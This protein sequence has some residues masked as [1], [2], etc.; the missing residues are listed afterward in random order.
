METGKYRDKRREREVEKETVIWTERQSETERERE[1][2]T[3][4]SLL[5]FSLNSNP[6]KA[7]L[8]A[9]MWHVSLPARSTGRG[10][11]RYGDI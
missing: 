4:C 3:E 1:R 11:E 6:F 9:A 2:R 7:A 10:T 8:N 5:S